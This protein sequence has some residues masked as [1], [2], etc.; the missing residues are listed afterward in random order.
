MKDCL[1]CKIA[2]KK[3]PSKIQYEDADIIAFDDTNPEAPVHILIVPKKHIESVI[4]LEIHD[5]ELV[6]KMIFAAK[7]IAKE[8]GLDGYKLLF[9]VG[10]SG[11]QLIDHIHLHLLGGQGSKDMI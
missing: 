5:I 4:K 11:G 3:L 7:K 8:R 6:G 10:R 2:R 1:F 9:N